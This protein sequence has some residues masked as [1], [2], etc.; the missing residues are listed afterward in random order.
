MSFTIRMERVKRMT[1]GEKIYR[2]RSERGLSQEAFGEMLGVSRQSVSKWETDQSSPELEKI[3]ALSELFGV[4][5]DYLLKENMKNMG[6]QEALPAAEENVR[7][8]RPHYEYK[9]RKTVR[10]IPLVHVNFG[11]GLYRAKGIFAVGNIASGVFALGF[12]SVG[13]VAFGLLSLGLLAFGSIAFGLVSIGTLA[14]GCIAFGAFTFG[15][16]CMG[17]LNFGQFCF[18]ALSYGK[19]VAIGDEAHGR[20]ALGFSRAVGELYQEVNE[21]GVFDYR[22]IEKLIDENVS[23]YWRPFREWMKWIVRGMG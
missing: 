12:V 6:R 17:A 4:S 19:Q 14:V 15:I 10:G 2:L 11:V 9:S 7:P 16:F 5:T 13:I 22:T 8:G 23:S 20:I 1:L 3:V 21:D 18:G